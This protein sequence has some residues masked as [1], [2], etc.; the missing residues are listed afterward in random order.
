MLANKR[1]IIE[2]MEKYDL[3]AI[4]A[5]HPENVSYL[6]DY[7]SHTPYMYRFLMLEVMLF[8]RGEMTLPLC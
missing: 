7:Q 5:S 1:R 4:I 8:F 6:S 3:D 2:K